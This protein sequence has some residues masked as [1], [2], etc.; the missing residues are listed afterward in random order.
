MSVSAVCVMLVVCVVCC[1]LCVVGF[2]V[3]CVVWC[4]VGLVQAC[5]YM[6]AFMAT[7]V[8][9]PSKSSSYHPKKHACYCHQCEYKTVNTL[10]IDLCVA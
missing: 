4:G 9:D 5:H 6:K 7:L 10:L 3:G 2:G 1:L 8:L